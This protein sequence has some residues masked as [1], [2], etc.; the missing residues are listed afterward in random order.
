MEI[1]PEYPL[2]SCQQMTV[3]HYPEA[4]GNILNIFEII[5]DMIV[6]EEG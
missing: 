4:L 5:F 3:Q 6:Q 2:N 1:I